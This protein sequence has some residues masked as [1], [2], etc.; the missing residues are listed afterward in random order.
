MG[1]VTVSKQASGQ[2]TKEKLHDWFRDQLEDMAEEGGTDSFCGNWNACGGLRI[3]DGTFTAETA[4][5]YGRKHRDKNGAVLAFRIGDFTA[6]WPVTKAQK[7]LQDRFAKLD[8]E[9]NEFDYRILERA[10]AQKTKTKKCTSCDSSINVHKI[11]KPALK[12]LTRSR[13]GSDDSGLAFRFGRYYLTS[14]FGMTDCPVCSQ[15]LLKTETDKKNQAALEKRL[16]EARAKAS[17]SRRAFDKGQVGK[18]QPY[19][20][21]TA[22]CGE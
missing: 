6:V 2:L 1:T 17:E 8:A 20:Y 14:Y 15:N 21:V 16:D 19:W 22:D 11:H 12:E 7:D 10:Q 5:A 9:S 13:G 3:V 18:P 4:A